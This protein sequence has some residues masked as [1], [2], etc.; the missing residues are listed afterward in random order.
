MK[1]KR[2]A[3]KSN[4]PAGPVKI[5]T[6]T[7]QPRD[8]ARMHGVKDMDTAHKMLRAAFHALIY[9]KPGDMIET[10]YAKFRK[11]SDDLIHLEV[12]VS[13]Q[14]TVDQLEQARVIRIPV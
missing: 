3:K 9:L 5:V 8:I 1:K 12:Q 6:R 2:N 13:L 14:M 7:L 11:V 4:G 10:S